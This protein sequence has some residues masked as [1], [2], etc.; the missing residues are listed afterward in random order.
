[1]AARM[2]ALAQS[3]L[4]TLHGSGNLRAFLRMIR[5][6]ESGQTEAAYRTIVGGGQVSDL[7][8]HPRQRVY[9]E[10]LR[11]WS[12]AAGA[13]QFLARTW[14]GC[15]RALGLT[16]FQAQSQDAA[17]VYLIRGRRA[18]DDVLAGRVQEAIRKCA[19][20]WA[21]LPGSPYGQPVMTMQRALDVYR[22]WGG[23]DLPDGAA[24]PIESRDVKPEGAMPIPVPIVTALLP[25]LIEAIPKLGRLF[26]SGSPT[27]ERNVAAAEVALEVV[28]QA[29]GARNAQEA[30]E[31]VQ[32]DTSAR[33][34]AEQAID[35]RWFA[36][37][38][39]GGGGIA[40]AREA[41]KTAPG[42]SRNPVLWVSAALLPLVYLVVSA[43]LFGEG[44][45]DEVRA[46][47]V[48]A[49]VTGALGA[50]TS[51]WLGTSISSSRKDDASRTTK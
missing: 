31:I 46:M 26:S 4:A 5:E 47:V 2:N 38:E 18:L 14:D 23:T 39:A 29:V 32:T 15:V 19:R 8:D 40:G 3:L 12:T 20:E 24:A 13:Y 41:V 9:I 28:Q 25:S 48:A 30:I 21:S 16:D 22:T 6:G 11:V 45:S 51:Y 35:A 49:V 7:T 1:M 27:A 37:T 36:L 44:W 42:P 34:L 17:A 50:I 43:V 33:A 10:A